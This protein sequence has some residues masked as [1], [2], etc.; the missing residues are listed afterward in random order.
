MVIVAKDLVFDKPEV[1][2]ERFVDAG[3]G[4][5]A[6]QL[7]DGCYVSVTEKGDFHT[8]ATEIK[9]WERCRRSGQIVTWY[10]AGKLTV[11]T[12]ALV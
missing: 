7:A 11:R 5:E 12:W 8:N 4:Y 10:G 3:G 1:I 2:A 9:G 6:L